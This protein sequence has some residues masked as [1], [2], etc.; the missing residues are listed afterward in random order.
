MA[1]VNIKAYTEWSWIFGDY[2]P[3]AYYEKTKGNEVEVETFHCAEQFFYFA[4]SIVNNRSL[5]EP[6]SIG[7][8]ALYSH[9]LPKSFKE[10]WLPPPY[11]NYYSKISKLKPSKPVFL[12]NNKYND[13]WNMGPQNYLSVEFLDKIFKSKISDV[14]E[15]YYIRYDGNCTDLLDGY[16]DDAVV[17]PDFGDYGLISK[18]KNIKTI[19]DVIDEH[20]IGFNEAQMWMLSHAKNIVS[21]NGGNAVLSAYFG[22][23]L[24][25]YGCNDCNST[26]RGIWKTNSWLKH[27]G[28]SNIFGYT[29]Y[30]LLLKEVE[31]KCI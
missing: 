13:E 16:H 27:L 19:Y 23:N 17:A 25:I 21:V 8:N 24:F 7:T 20:R 10:N 22:E 15:F 30:E 11:K 31:E 2:V 18:Y 28:G 6:P 4:D 9:E 5:M 12:I 29:D 1:K 3:S 26:N 14:F